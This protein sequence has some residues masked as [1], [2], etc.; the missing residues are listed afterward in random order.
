MH[1]LL[2]RLP[3]KIKKEI[4]TELLFLDIFTFLNS[5]IFVVTIGVPKKVIDLIDV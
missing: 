1:Q 2:A 4:L 3:P 5:F